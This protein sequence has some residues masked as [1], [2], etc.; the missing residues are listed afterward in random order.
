MPAVST[1]CK[2]FGTA[3]W[4]P[5]ATDPVTSGAPTLSSNHDANACPFGKLGFESM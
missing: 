1:S 5:V 3:I 4:T 2:L